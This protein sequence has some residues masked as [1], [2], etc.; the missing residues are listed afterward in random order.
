MNVLALPVVA[1]FSFLTALVFGLAAQ[2]LL[3]VRLGLVRLFVAGVFALFVNWPIQAALLGDFAEREPTRA[4]AVPVV[5]FVLLA[6]A[7]TVLASMA[8]SW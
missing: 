4:D 2:R 5:F 1:T 8:S 6:M 7:C 3:G